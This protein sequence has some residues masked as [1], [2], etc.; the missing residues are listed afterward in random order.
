MVRLGNFFSLPSSPVFLFFI[1]QLALSRHYKIYTSLMVHIYIHWLKSQTAITTDKRRANTSTI[2]TLLREGP[3]VGTPTPGFASSDLGLCYASDH[4]RTTP[5]Y[6]MPQTHLSWN[7]LEG[8]RPAR[9]LVSPTRLA[10]HHV[11][12]SWL[13]TS[14]TCLRWKGRPAS[15]Q[16]MARSSR[17]L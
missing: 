6:N 10:C 4:S 2:G 3:P 12:S 16:G 17:G 11:G 7:C 15:W 8:M 5:P 1:F 13:T 9:R 14:R